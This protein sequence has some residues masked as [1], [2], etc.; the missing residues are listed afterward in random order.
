[1]QHGDPLFQRTDARTLDWQKKEKKKKALS[2]AFQNFWGNIAQCFQIS[3]SLNEKPKGGK[4]DISICS[5]FFLYVAG[6]EQL[7]QASCKQS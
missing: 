1:M 3:F 4:K 5:S 2:Q 7:S 6:C